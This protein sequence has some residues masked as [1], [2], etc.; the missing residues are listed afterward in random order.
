MPLYD[1][2]TL[3]TRLKRGPIEPNEAVRVARQL[4]DGLSR[5]HA[6]GIIH[7][8]VKPGNVLITPDGT[9]KILD[10]G[11]AKLG[12]ET[13]T[14]P[15]VRLGSLSYMSP[16]QLTGGAPDPSTDIWSVGVVLFEMLTGR[17][18]FAG[19]RQDAVIAA[20]L[21]RP[22]DL[23]GVP[24]APPGL[25][26]IVERCLEKSSD[27]RYGSIAALGAALGD[28]QAGTDRGPRRRRW[29]ALGAVAGAVSAMALVVF[30]IV[31][32]LR[33][34]APAGSQPIGIAVLPFEWLGGSGDPVIADAVHS[35]L[36][37]TFSQIGTVRVVSRASVLPYRD[38]GAE[39]SEI[40]RRFAVKFIV[41]GSVRQ[42]AEVLSVDVRL[43]DAST[44]SV[45]WGSVFRGDASASGLH[46][47]KTAVARQVLASVQATLSAA[48]QQRLRRLPPTE[49]L[50]ALQLVERA[51]SAFDGTRAGSIET[52]RLARGAL[53]SDSAY[54]DAWVALG[55]ALGFRPLWHGF[56]V[57]YWDS[58]LAAAARARALDPLAAGPLAIEA[59]V[60]THQGLLGL[61]EQTARQAL[62]LEPSSWVAARHLELSVQE[63]GRL[64]E[65]VLLSRDLLRLAPD[66]PV[67]Q[68]YLGHTYVTLGLVHLAD[69]IY[70]AILA[71][72]PGF[73]GAFDGLSMLALAQG[74]RDSAVAL[75]RAGVRANADDPAS[76]AAGANTAHYAG[77]HELA[78]TLASR[79]LLIGEGEASS[80]WDMLSTTIFAYSA[81]RRGS[82]RLADSLYRVSREFLNDRLKT[83]ATWWRWPY[84]LGLIHAASGVREQALAHLERA[85][86]AGLRGRW[87]LVS[88]PM[89]QS[90]QREPRFVRLVARVDSA[91]TAMRL[92]VVR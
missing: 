69:S 35:E 7:R 84:E 41:E 45:V 9:V 48:E 40:A 21:H 74:Q 14:G 91:V 75:A 85:V 46:T 60:Y 33:S 29:R 23:S 20:I 2:E 80:G 87:A 8:D 66:H 6:N 71:R 59:R 77:D 82:A 5:A 63:Q 54:A 1:G 39:P 42:E 92:R 22:P 57:T 58:A 30:A 36:L 79:A 47:A 12:A 15:H 13:F 52:E 55:E 49:N 64:D 37:T 10:F 53:E 68:T 26:R 90:L 86:D 3:D 44:S 81:Q 19:D 89:L 76:I 18:P 16:E 78:A 31:N 65:A 61:A 32:W 4:C 83:G 67:A 62:R 34:P 38:S 17:Q 24:S 28:V 73:W 72:E 43:T 70:R 56:S 88:N 50:R 25:A 11:I 51:R 27:R